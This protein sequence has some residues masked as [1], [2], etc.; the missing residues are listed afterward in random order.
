MRRTGRIVLIADDNAAIRRHLCETFT[1]HEFQVC[2]EATNGKE[3]IKKA[4]ECR[5][6]L[7]ILDLAMPL[8]NGLEAAPEIHKSLPDVPIILYTL[9]SLNV[10]RSELEARGITAVVSKSEPIENLIEKAEQLFQT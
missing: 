4:A 1:L 3:A 10:S 8:M 2:A 7:V 9:F 5:P 6:E